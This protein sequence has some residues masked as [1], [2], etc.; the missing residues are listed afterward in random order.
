M[1]RVIVA[2]AVWTSGTLAPGIDNLRAPMNP[3]SPASSTAPAATALPVP[4]PTTYPGATAWPVAVDPGSLAL[5][6]IEPPPVQSTPAQT[7]PGRSAYAA[8]Q[9]SFDRLENAG[10]F[11]FDRL[12]HVPQQQMV[13]EPEEIV[14]AELGP[15]RLRACYVRLDAFHW[16][17]EFESLEL[18]DESGMLVT[19][20]YGQRIGNARLRV[21]LFG[22][23]MDYQGYAQNAYAI[24]PYEQSDGTSYLGFR[25]EF[26]FLLEPRS[27]LKNRIVLGI[28]S[29]CWRRDLHDGQLP[30]GHTVAGYE[31]TWVTLYPY[32]GIETK[33]SMEP[34]LHFFTSARLGLTPYTYEHISV[35]ESLSPKCGTMGRLELGLRGE[36]FLG[37]VLMEIMTWEKSNIVDGYFQPSSSMAT[38]GG[39]VAYRY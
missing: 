21:E 13:I 32:V 39:R 2:L 3:T 7:V 38:L 11:S 14:D 18:V 19:I 12:D 34:G 9:D 6:S 30:T 29:R 35:G 20:G 31:E 17:E 27:W 5:E 37:S 8:G 16:S 22:G 1:S 10:S 36:R 33:E 26:E 28:G 25:G 4:L 24:I 23:Q 15:Q